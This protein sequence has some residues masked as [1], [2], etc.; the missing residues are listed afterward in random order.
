MIKHNKFIFLHL[1]KC[2]G[3]FVSKFLEKYI[4]GCTWIHAGTHNG[5][6]SKPLDKF[7]FGVVRNPFD[8]YVSWYTKG[9]HVHGH[10]SKGKTF[11]E[12]IK[13]LYQQSG[14]L[15]DI[16]IDACNSDNIGVFTFRHN[17]TFKTYPDYVCKFENLTNDLI[18]CFEVNK[19]PLSPENIL[20]LKNMEKQNTSDHKH[21]SEYYD[22][23]TKKIIEERESFII[24][25]Y[26]YEFEY[27]K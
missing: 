23:V 22:D 15:H 9:T 14:M 17:K 7:I 12:F 20:I 6:N 24:K 21:Y 4:D 1:Q 16:N 8:W 19:L 26:G 25:K 13:Q 3:T 11:P 18:K 2:A 10:F 27:N 5:L